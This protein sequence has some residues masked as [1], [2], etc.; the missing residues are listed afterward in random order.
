MNTHR[1]LVLLSKQLVDEDE[2]EYVIVTHIASVP[3]LFISLQP[4]QV[5]KEIVLEIYFMEFFDCS[6]NHE[7][8]DRLRL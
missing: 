1:P 6:W 3:L 4:S 8:M 5:S 7:G 2:K